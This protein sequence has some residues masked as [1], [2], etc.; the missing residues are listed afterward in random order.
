MSRRLALVAKARVHRPAAGRCR[1]HFSTDAVALRSASHASTRWDPCKTRAAYAATS[2]VSANR[3]ALEA[4]PSTVIKMCRYG[5]GG[6]GGAAGRAFAAAAE[7]LAPLF[8]ADAREAEPPAPAP[9]RDAAVSAAIADAAAA[10]NV[11][12]SLEDRWLRAS[13]VTTGCGDP[14]P[15]MAAAPLTDPAPA[16]AADAA[17]PVVDPESRAC[18]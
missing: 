7:D 10:A 8:T 9:V 5:G 14:R 11:A 15:G 16:I 6:G 17:P 3:E 12:V 4:D 2:C 13:A 18:C 1:F